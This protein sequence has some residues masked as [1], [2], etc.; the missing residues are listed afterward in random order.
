MLYKYLKIIIFCAS[1]GVNGLISDR[2]YPRYHLAPPKGWM[3]DP[4]G[5]AMFKGEYHLF[6]Q[7]NPDSSLTSETVHWGHAKSPDLFHWE[8]LGVA[9]YPD[10]PYD[11]SGVFSGSAYVEGDTIYFYYTGNVN[12]P[13]ENPD[14][15]NTQALAISTDGVNL[16]KYEKNPI[17]EGADRQPD[18]RD[19]K[20]WKH[21]D[22]YYMVLGNSYKNSKGDATGRALLYSSKDKYNWKEESV[23]AESNGTQGYMWECPDFFELNGKYVLLFSPQGMAPEGD[24][25][26]NLYQTGYLVGDFDYNTHAYKTD[27]VFREI[28]HGHDFYASQTIVNKRGERIVVGWFDMWE[29]QYPEKADGFTGQMTLPRVL[30]LT[31]QGTILQKP[32]TEISKALGKTAYSGIASQN[33]VVSLQDNIGEI[34]VIAHAN[35]NFTLYIESEDETRRVVLSYDAKRSLVTLDRG[36]DDNIRRTTWKASPV[37]VWDIFI[38]T[39]SIELFCGRGEVTFSSRFF[40]VGQVKVRPGNEQ[41]ILMTVNG[42]KRTMYLPS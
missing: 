9:M 8:D 33:T 41:P 15:A 12:M 22:T 39:S 35:K 11:K 17:I 20:V 23:L 18:F 7:Y 26:K 32:V 2:Y 36:G 10:Q 1:V 34:K 30:T 19:P 37:L 25:Y 42:M 3:N 29:T 13:G 27:G 21:G 38:D 24:K 16:V 6:Y 5:F 28:D 4:N 40:P 14:H 31:K